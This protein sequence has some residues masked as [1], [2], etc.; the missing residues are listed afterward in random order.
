MIVEGLNFC[1]FL[2]IF[3]LSKHLGS[4]PK[5]PAD[6]K[7]VHIMFWPGRTA[8]TH[9]RVRF[10]SNTEIV[11]KLPATNEHCIRLVSKLSFHCLCQLGQKLKFKNLTANNITK[12]SFWVTSRIHYLF[13]IPTYIQTEKNGKFETFQ[14][15]EN[16]P[17]F[18]LSHN[19]VKDVNTTFFKDY[20][21]PFISYAIKTD[22][23]TLVNIL[24]I[25]I[26]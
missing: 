9:V 18:A 20:K 1:H 23:N 8:P 13:V 16:C 17:V 6:W 15:D 25:C 14:I 4:L 19:R 2:N 26:H 24:Y 10:S 5:N 22:D 21:K 7:K 11:A 3:F 12:Y